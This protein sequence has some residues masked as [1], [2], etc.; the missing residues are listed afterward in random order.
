MADPSPSATSMERTSVGMPAIASACRMCSPTTG[1]PGDPHR[2]LGLAAVDRD[3]GSYRDV[4]GCRARRHRIGGSVARRTRP[5]A[6]N[7]LRTTAKPTPTSPCQGARFRDPVWQPSGDR[8]AFQSLEKDHWEIFVANND[9]G[10]PTALTR[11]ATTLVPKLPQNVSPSWSPDGR[12]IAFLSDRSGKWAVWVMDANGANQ[13][14]L[15]IDV[16]IEYRNQGEQ[17]LSWGK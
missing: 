13:R 5:A 15:P 6:S 17:M 16:P 3:G 11:P 10:N 1:A 14:M 9:R 8:I 12:S 7:R 4:P 2:P